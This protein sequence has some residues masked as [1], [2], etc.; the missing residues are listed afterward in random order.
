M[1]NTLLKSINVMIESQSEVDRTIFMDL[2]ETGE[3]QTGWETVVYNL[4]KGQ[5][6][7]V[8]LD[9]LH[10]AAELEYEFENVPSYTDDDTYVHLAH[11]LRNTQQDLTPVYFPRFQMLMQWI[12]L[13]GLSREVWLEAKA[14]DYMTYSAPTIIM[15]ERLKYMYE[16]FQQLLLDVQNKTLNMQW[17]RRE[18]DIMLE[19]DVLFSIRSAYPDYKYAVLR[20]GKYQKY[21]NKLGFQVVRVDKSIKREG[22]T[23]MFCLESYQ[24]ISL[25][26]ENP[27]MRPVMTHRPNPVAHVFH[28][29]CIKTWFQMS[30]TTACPYKDCETAEFVGT[31][32][33]W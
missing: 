29:K 10:R 31:A 22:M 4:I 1:G 15:L 11:L 19:E 24:D 25:D 21:V 16:D 14:Y 20:T 8:Q 30:G 5:D 3:H 26:K 13:Y 17:T 32:G 18:E 6:W 9:R 27:D 23:C 12:C 2:Y 33:F 28:F 7:Q